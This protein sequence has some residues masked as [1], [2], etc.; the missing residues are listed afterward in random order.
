MNR[1]PIRLSPVVAS[2][3]VANVVVGILLATVFTHPAVQEVLQFD[4]SL[5]FQHPWTFITYLFVHPG[6]LALGLNLIL[7]MGF[8]LNLERRMGGP[9]FLAYYLACGIGAAVF[10]LGLTS[11]TNV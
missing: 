9:S 11:F 4:A 10:A 8:G 5:A 1:D 6:I 7:L 3:A 2:L